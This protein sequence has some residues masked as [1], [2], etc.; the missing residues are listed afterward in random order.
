MV[1]EI[2]LTVDDNHELADF[3]G[4]TLIPHLGYQSR[5]AY[6]ASQCFKILKKENIALLLLDYN[7]PD[8]SGLDLLRKLVDEQI[9]V[10]T[11]LVTAEGSEQ[12]AAEA[13]R[14]GVYD[15]LAKPIEADQLSNA[16][17]RV[18]SQGRIRREKELLTIKLKEQFASQAVLSPV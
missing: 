9:S 6:S 11:I 4:N 16:I 7:L 3:C 12:I 18:L 14:L 2:I 5:V 8:M 10:P 17:A 1:P 15:Y 13:F